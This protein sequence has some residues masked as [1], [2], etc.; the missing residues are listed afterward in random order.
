ATTAA[1]AAAEKFAAEA[2]ASVAEPVRRDLTVEE[3]IDLEQQADFFI[4][5][6]QEEAAI[7]L[8]MGHVRSSGGASPMPYL[9][10]LDIYRRRSDREAYAR[11]RERFNR[12]FNAYA[13][14]YESDPRDG[15]TLERYAPVMAR[16]QAV[17]PTPNKAMDLLQ[18]LLFRRDSSDGTF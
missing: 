4:V 6:G 7:D 8:L 2:S 12:R 18:S 10:L 16:L 14:E 9:K 11:I 13:P 17:W 5:L 1:K 3:L 15:R